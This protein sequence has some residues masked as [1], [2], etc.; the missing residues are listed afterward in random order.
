M[1]ETRSLGTSSFQMQYEVRVEDPQTWV[2]PWTVAF[3]VRR[4]ESYVMYEY[5]CHEGNYAIRHV[6]SAARASEL[7]RTPR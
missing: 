2:R 6:L 3:P 5:A 4:D 7:P 1:G